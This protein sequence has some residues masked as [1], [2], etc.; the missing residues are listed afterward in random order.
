[1]VNPET[2]PSARG[3]PHSDPAMLHGSRSGLT[4]SGPVAEGAQVLTTPI[5]AVR[6]T[7]Y[8]LQS[9]VRAFLGR[10]NENVPEISLPDMEDIAMTLACMKAA[11]VR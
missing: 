8:G 3:Q 1:M 4:G 7:L 11:N 2:P 9:T 6:D 10:S 5:R